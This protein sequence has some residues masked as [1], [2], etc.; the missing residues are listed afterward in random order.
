[1]SQ[2]VPIDNDVGSGVEGLLEF[3]G[4]AE[5]C[6]HVSDGQTCSAEPS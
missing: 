5:E 2:M 6:V 4:G 1:M 3:L